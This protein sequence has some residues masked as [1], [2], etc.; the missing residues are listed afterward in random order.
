MTSESSLA[1][2]EREGRLKRQEP[3]M[4][5]MNDLLDAAR[6]NFEAAKVVQGKIDEAAFKLYYDGLLQIGRVVLLGAGFRPADG[7]QHKT[8]FE[9]AGAILGPEFSDLIRK[10]QKFRI[11]RNVCVYDP[12]DL[13]GKAET[14]AIQRTARSFWAKVRRYLADRDPQL[15]LFEGI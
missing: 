11:K 7:E 2:L 14:D 5:A 13:I 4:G 9:A 12:G 6:R 8:T 10:I 3:D 1:R 15:R